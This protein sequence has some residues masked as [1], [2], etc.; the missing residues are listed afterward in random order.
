MGYPIPANQMTD[1]GDEWVIGGTLT[2]EEGA[3]VTGLTGQTTFSSDA[4]V[5]AGTVT[6]KVTSPKTV[7]TAVGMLTAINFVGKNGAGACTAT[8]L[9]VDDVILSVTG[10]AAA[11]VGDKSTLFESVVTVA[12]EIQQSSASNLSTKVYTALIKRMS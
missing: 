7:A 2:I 9:K 11:D 5:K 3:T 10:V 12:D 6:T 8:G 1:G 4:E